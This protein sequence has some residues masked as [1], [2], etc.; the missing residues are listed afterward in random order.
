MGLDDR[1]YYY[2]RVNPDWGRSPHQQQ[3]LFGMGLTPV[4]KWLLIINV[5]VFVITRLLA[6]HPF[7][8]GV[9]MVLVN[10]VP[11]AMQGPSPFELMFG[12]YPANLIGR[13]MVWQLVTY[14]FLHGGFLHLLFNM[15]ALLMFGAHVERQ[16][17]SR[18][19]LRLYLL[20]G[21]FAG[22]VNIVPHVF[23]KV[24]TVGA[25]GALCAVVAAFAL[26]NPNSRIA[27][28]ILFFP[29]FVKAKTFVLIY[30]LITVF[31]ALTA[32]GSIAHL[33]HLGGLV[34]GWMYVYNV[35]QVRWLVDGRRPIRSF[36]AP[37]SW[38]NPLRA[39]WRKLRGAAHGPRQYRGQPY[40]DGD[41]SE[42]HKSSQPDANWDARID[43]ILDK[44]KQRGSDSLS[45]EEWEV[46]RR[47]RGR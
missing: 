42:V 25:S 35:W 16:I 4:V 3:S 45:S 47:Y 6:A 46:L 12:L 30:A 10:G 38:R 41:F 21:I 28:L 20:G 33:A 11:R 8:S 13:F 15:F 9:E 37:G 36:D 27:F 40:A 18:P 31:Q 34:F 24:P 44:M 26:M 14:Q 5:A 7:F 23:V 29:V 43:A 32:T 1:D 2:Q 39:L 17:G 22:L 19:F